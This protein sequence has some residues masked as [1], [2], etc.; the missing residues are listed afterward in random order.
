MNGHVHNSPSPEPRRERRV[1]TRPWFIAAA[2]AAA[3]FILVPPFNF[4]LFILVFCSYEL[5][6]YFGLP[7]SAVTWL[8]VATYRVVTRRP[9]KRVFPFALKA[10][11]MVPVA[12]GL[13]HLLLA[14]V[15]T[16][17]FTQVAG[18]WFRMKHQADIPA[19]RHWAAAYEAESDGSGVVSVRW[20]AGPDCIRELG[21]PGYIR[22][23]P[24]KQRVSISWGSGHGHWGLIVGPVDMRMGV[25]P[26]CFKLEDGAYVL[27][28]D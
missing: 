27:C 19:I 18:L 24:G 2:V 20:D 14:L 15:A 8:G 10:A 22:F 11:V 3:I 7:V 16:G 12:V 4:V 23:Y 9:G 25:E 21:P 17:G 28:G 1:W 5:F 13:L 26:Y 6:L